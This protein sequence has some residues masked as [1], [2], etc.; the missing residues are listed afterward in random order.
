MDLAL[1]MDRSSPFASPSWLA[2]AGALWLLTWGGCGAGPRDQRT[3]SPTEF[4]LNETAAT[5]RGVGFGASRARVVEKFG[6]PER[7]SKKYGVS[8]VGELYVD[9]GLPWVVAPPPD[10]GSYEDA[11]AGVLRYRGVSFQSTSRSGV[12]AF[13]VSARG[14]VTNR[15]VRIGDPLRRAQ[16]LYPELRCEVRNEGT[17]YVKYPYCAGRLGPGR[18]IWFGEDPIRSISMATRPMG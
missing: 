9:L 8:P 11:L 5:F 1:D 16:E 18:H 4:R 6:R 12:Y 17:E 14:T 15:G 7:Y 3:S 10:R 13:F 2:I